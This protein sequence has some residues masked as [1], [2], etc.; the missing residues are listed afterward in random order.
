MTQKSFPMTDNSMP[1]L[2]CCARQWNWLRPH[3]L[4]PALLPV[5]VPKPKELVNHTYL[6]YPGACYF[7]R[8]V[9]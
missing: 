3:L 4:S 6:T 5:T 7:V 9:G 1:V 2:K 8:V